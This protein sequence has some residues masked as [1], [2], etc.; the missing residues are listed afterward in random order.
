MYEGLEKSIYLS[1]FSLPSLEVRLDAPSMV[2]L[3]LQDI[4]QTQ[5]HWVLGRTAG[6]IL[7]SFLEI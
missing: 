1:P 2:G 4:L 5:S 3:D 7:S 6:L